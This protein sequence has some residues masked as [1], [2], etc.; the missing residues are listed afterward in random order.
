MSNTY[1]GSNMELITRKGNI[2]YYYNTESG[3]YYTWTVPVS[4]AGGFSG[5]SILGYQEVTNESELSDLKAEFPY[6]SDDIKK[7]TILI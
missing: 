3:K 5:G 7:T 2:E 4:G 1:D 6:G